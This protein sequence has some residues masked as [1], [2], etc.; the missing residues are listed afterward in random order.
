MPPRNIPAPGACQPRWAF[1]PL[2]RRVTISVLLLTW[3]ASWLLSMAWFHHVNGPWELDVDRKVSIGG[4]V[5][6]WV[7][8]PVAFCP[9]ALPVSAARATMAVFCWLPIGAVSSLAV[10]V[11]FAFWPAYITLLFLALKT[12]RRRYLAI[13]CAMGLFASIHWHSECMAWLGI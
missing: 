11:L 4:W 8:Y 7:V 6:S 2:R 9:I 13:L 3:A 12:G 1:R 10:I 5:S